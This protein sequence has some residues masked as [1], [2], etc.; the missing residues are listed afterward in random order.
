MRELFH[1]RPSSPSTY[2]GELRFPKRALKS[3]L[4]DTSI[5]GT[6]TQFVFL[7]K[8]RTHHPEVRSIDLGSNDHLNLDS[9]SECVG[10]YL[11]HREG[12]SLVVG[13]FEPSNVW[14][15]NADTVL[16]SL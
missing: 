12:M 6:R 4:R 1:A 10:D 8:R 11:Q 2:K 7:E 16:S 13:V 14:L 9:L 5:H 3:W 15:E